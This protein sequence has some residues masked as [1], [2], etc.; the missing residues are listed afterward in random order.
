MQCF[1]AKQL[2]LSKYDGYQHEFASIVCNFFHKK[3]FGANILGGAI[4]RR[5]KSAIRIKFTSNQRPSELACVA[6]GFDSTRKL[7]EELHKPAIRKLEKRK[8][9]PYFKDIICGADLADM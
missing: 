6:K 5:N 2:Y 3:S 7:A 4:T 8:I 1:I 9:Y